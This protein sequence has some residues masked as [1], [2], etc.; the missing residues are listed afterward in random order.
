M[1]LCQTLSLVLT[2]GERLSRGWFPSSPPAPG[3]IRRQRF[4][5]ALGTALLPLTWSSCQSQSHSPSKYS[6]TDVREGCTKGLSF[7]LFSQTPVRFWEERGALPFQALEPS[8]LYISFLPG[9]VNKCLCPDSREIHQLL[10]AECNV[11]VKKSYTTQYVR[12]S[13]ECLIHR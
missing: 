12:V 6:G 1:V 2:V 13:R 5:F 11:H 3:L 10:K 9:M 8:L 4:H 7:P